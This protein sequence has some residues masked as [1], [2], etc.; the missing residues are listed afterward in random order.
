MNGIS[1]GRKRDPRQEKE[2]IPSEQEEARMG[3][4]FFV[5]DVGAIIF[6]LNGSLI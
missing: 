1:Q 6:C 2:G 3:L 5:V 4:G